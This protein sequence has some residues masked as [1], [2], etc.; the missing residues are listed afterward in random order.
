MTTTY[1]GGEL[2]QLYL[3]ACE[4]DDAYSRALVKQYG[5]AEAGDARYYP[6]ERHN[7]ET[8]SARAV[9]LA[10]DAEMRAT[11]SH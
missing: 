4:A 9:K 2:H 7:A 11:W 1:T 3:R 6:A 5:E 8:L 10:A